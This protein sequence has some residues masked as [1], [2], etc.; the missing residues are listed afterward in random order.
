MVQPIC[1]DVYRLYS[2]ESKSFCIVVSIFVSRT[3][4]IIVFVN[5]Y[6]FVIN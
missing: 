5:Q 6:Y 3:E 1:I 2:L 4:S